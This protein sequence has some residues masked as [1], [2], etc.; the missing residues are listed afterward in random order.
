MGIVCH[1]EVITVPEEVAPVS[2]GEAPE[3]RQHPLY[4]GIGIAGT[5][6][7]KGGNQVFKQLSLGAPPGGPM[8]F[9]ENDG[10]PSGH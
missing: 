4:R 5:M 7:Q 8:V 1:P 3:S 6:A 9:H 2:T 10:T